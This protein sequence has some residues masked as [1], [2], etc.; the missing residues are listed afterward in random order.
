M[1][2]YDTG[3]TPRRVNISSIVDEPTAIEWL[4]YKGATPN[5]IGPTTRIDPDTGNKFSTYKWITLIVRRTAKQVEA[6]GNSP[7][8][9]YKLQALLAKVQGTKSDT[10][11]GTLEQSTEYGPLSYAQKMYI[12]DHMSKANASDIANY[13]RTNPQNVL[14]AQKGQFTLVSASQPLV[15]TYRLNYNDKLAIRD[16]RQGES[17]SAI[18]REY[19][20]SLHSV[21]KALAGLFSPPVLGIV[22]HSRPFGPLSKAEKIHVRDNRSDEPTAD[23]AREYNTSDSNIRI[24]QRGE[25]KDKAIKQQQ[26]SHM[27]VLSLM[28]QGYKITDKDG[29]TKPLD[30]MFTALLRGK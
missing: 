25:F 16:T 27:L 7:L 8:D 9:Q 28:G 4:I 6:A 13:V 18:A 22:V 19:K 12:R 11:F 29:N 5:D 1:S 15:S 30:D 10:D 24:A 17:P 23:L 26:S 20:C 21:R 14:L 2:F 3:G